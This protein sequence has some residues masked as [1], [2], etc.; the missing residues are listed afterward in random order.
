MRPRYRSAAGGGRRG[1]TRRGPRRPR[2]ESRRPPRHLPR[3]APSI[4]GAAITPRSPP[5][6]RGRSA[7]RAG[8]QPRVPW[9]R[10]SSSRA[11]T[12]RGACGVSPVPP[13]DRR[14]AVP[15]PPLGAGLW[16]PPPRQ[17]SISQR[18]P[19]PDSIS[20]DA[21]RPPRRWSPADAGGGGRPGRAGSA[22]RPAAAAGVPPAP[23]GTG[24]AR[25]PSGS[26]SAGGA[27]PRHPPQLRLPLPPPAGA[28]ARLVRAGA[29][30]VPLR[31]GAA[32]PARAPGCGWV[33]ASFRE[34]PREEPA[35]LPAECGQ[36]AGPRPVLRH[37]PAPAWPGWGRLRVC[38]RQAVGWDPGS[39]GRREALRSLPSPLPAPSHRGSGD[40]LQRGDPGSRGGGF[41]GLCVAG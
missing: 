32:G 20:Q 37:P 11:A 27:G 1:Q 28:A 10:Q 23:R 15:S 34:A 6:R 16:Q 8:R 31:R 36:T 21:P 25:R 39:E 13:R 12:L 33:S 3:P 24:A 2:A 41:G 9:S 17:D 40:V 4:S 26:G 7:G 35:V 30:P 38:S 29:R 5:A 14:R 18:A 22:G 19:R